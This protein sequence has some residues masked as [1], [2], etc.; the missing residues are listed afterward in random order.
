MEGGRRKR[1]SR[2]EYFGKEM[3]VDHGALYQPF[4]LFFL[5][6]GMPEPS[7]ECQHPEAWL[8]STY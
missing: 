6:Y 3:D 8:A 4:V 1:K 5:L 2:D 7:L